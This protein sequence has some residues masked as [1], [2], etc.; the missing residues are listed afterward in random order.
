MSTYRP[1]SGPLDAVDHCHELLDG[2]KVPRQIPAG[3]SA[4]LIERT[5]WLVAEVKRLQKLTTPSAD[6]HSKVT[7]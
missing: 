6:A 3:R 5:A 1:D 2:A 7:P 4:G